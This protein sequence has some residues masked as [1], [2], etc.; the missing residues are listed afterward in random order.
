M[1]C[2][3]CSKKMKRNGKNKYG[4]QQ[5]YC[6]HCHGY[7]SVR[8]RE[9][10]RLLG[11]PKIHTVK[12]S[13]MQYEPSRS[14]VHESAR[15]KIKKVVMSTEGFDCLDKAALADVVAH[16]YNIPIGQVNHMIECVLRANGVKIR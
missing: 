12:V 1:N 16:D 11:A 4:N 6:R 9:A 7:K 10:G 8:E 5:W 2:P 14:T 3:T 15:T 13:E